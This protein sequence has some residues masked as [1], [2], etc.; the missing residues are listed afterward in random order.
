MTPN[1]NYGIESF[2]PMNFLK[3]IIRDN[4]FTNPPLRSLLRVAICR[5]GLLK[6]LADRFRI[7]GIC[8]LEIEGIP[9][10]V[11]SE[12]DDFIANELFYNLGYESSEYKLIQA[13]V[14]KSNYLVDVGANTG[15]FSI[16]AAKANDRLTV[17][18]FEPHPGNFQRFQTNIELNGLQNVFPHE[19]ALGE[20]DG[21]IKFTV[22]NNLSISATSSANSSLMA[23]SP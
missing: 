19:K 10:T 2:S 13:L 23:M 14:V 7:Y 8:K 12:G 9:L 4:K 17:M 21:E 16:F 20:A 5:F 22:P 6:G 1:S 18:S 15:I 11:Y 3:T